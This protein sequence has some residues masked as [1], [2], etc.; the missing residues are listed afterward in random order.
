MEPAI[1]Y[2]TLKPKPGTFPNEIGS[3]RDVFYVSHIR[4][5]ADPSAAQTLENQWQTTHQIIT[6]EAP[7]KIYFICSITEVRSRLIF[8]NEIDIATLLGLKPDCFCT[9]LT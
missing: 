8:S 9:I 2:Q 5:E 3:W 4:M 6:E 7:C 1:L